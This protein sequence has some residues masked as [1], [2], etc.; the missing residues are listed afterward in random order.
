M[1]NIP[2]EGAFVIVERATSTSYGS[3][4]RGRNRMTRNLPRRARRKIHIACSAN[5]FHLNKNEL[6]TMVLGRQNE[7]PRWQHCFRRSRLVRDHWTS[8]DSRELGAARLTR[9]D[10]GNRPR[11]LLPNNF[12]LSLWS[13]QT[14]LQSSCRSSPTHGVLCI[15]PSNRNGGAKDRRR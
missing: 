2:T 11:V 10:G 5:S 13:Y 6:R 9:Q 12:S 15:S 1:E 3:R 7:L 8:P 4:K 14:L